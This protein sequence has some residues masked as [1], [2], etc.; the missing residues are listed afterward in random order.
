MLHVG[1]H[2]LTLRRYVQHYDTTTRVESKYLYSSATNY[3]SVQQPNWGNASRS[4]QQHIGG[5]ASIL[6]LV[7]ALFSM[8]TAIV[9]SWYRGRKCYIGVA[10]PILQPT[11]G[12]ESKIDKG[13]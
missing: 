6:A 7:P 9:V 3:H 10:I 11:M 12:S 4:A 1:V 13:Q 5:A 8:N 2:A